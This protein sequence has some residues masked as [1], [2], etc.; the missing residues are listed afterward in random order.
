MYLLNHSSTDCFFNLA[1]EEYFVKNSQEDFFLLWQ[2]DNTIVVGKNQNTLEEIN[3]PYV[4]EHNI[5][6][7]RRMT[8]GGA[9]YH[10]LGN[11]NFSII[12][13]TEKEHFNDY[14]YFT[15]PV[16]LFLQTLGLHVQLS[17]RNDLTLCG[18]KF[19]GNAQACFG[20]RLLH[21]GTI[22]FDSD[23]TCLSKALTPNP[24]KIDSKGIKS[25]RSRVTNLK[26]SLS[27]DITVT[28]FMKSLTSYLLHSIP[29]LQEHR[30]TP[31]ETAAIQSLADKKYR[32]WEWNYG[33]SPPFT[34]SKSRKY[35][36]GIVTLHLYIESGQLRTLKIYGD[37]FG[38]KET[39]NL[40]EKLQNTVFRYETILKT[41]ELISVSDYIEG[42]D[43]LEF[44]DLLFH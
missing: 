26:S 37:F 29:N 44:C 20:N 8:G 12:Q 10:D 41:L 19:S 14:A 33:S 18:M 22:L 7:V 40:E 17:G 43:A 38:K 2:N 13:T 6:V 9:V 1:C 27:D 21:H 24:L 32:T 34:L 15:Q 28:A 25:V 23:I 11:V 39:E 30:L 3:H 36:F 5:R 4:T 16:C 31:E 42:M 35:P